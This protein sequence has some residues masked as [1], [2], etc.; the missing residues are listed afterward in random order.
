LIAQLQAQ[1]A[2]LQAQILELIQAQ[3][4]SSSWCYTFNE[5][6]IQG[7]SGAGV[8]ALQAAMQKSGYIIDSS[9]VAST[10]FGTSTKDAVIKFQQK[11]SSEILSPYGYTSGTGIVGLMTRTKLNNLY[12]CSTTDTDDDV[13]VT[14]V[15][16]CSS[17]YDCGNTGFTGDAFCSSG[18]VYQ[19]YTTYTCKNAGKSN[20]FCSVGTTY[21]ARDNCSSS[22]V[23]SNGACVAVS[24]TDDDNDDNDDDDNEIVCTSSSSC[25]SSGYTGDA[26]CQSGNVYKAYK[27]Y[28]CNNPGISSSYCSSS[29][30]DKLFDT[31]SSSETCSNGS[32]VAKEDD[33]TTTTTCT[34]NWSCGSWTTCSS[35]YQTRSCY[36]A[37]YCGVTTNKPSEQQSCTSSCTPNW[38]C[39]SWGTCS[40]SQQT[41]SCYDTNYCGVT[42]NKPSEQQSCTS[43]CTPDWSCGSW[44]TCVNSLQTRYCYDTNYCGSQANKPDDYQSCVSSTNGNLSVDLK[45]NGG[46]GPITVAKGSTVSFVWSSTDVNSCSASTS[47]SNSYWSGN[48]ATSGIVSV[49]VNATGTYYL[50]CTNADGDMVED[51]VVINVVSVDLKING[52]ESLTLPYKSTNSLTL[53][54]SSSGVNSCSVTST[55][56][57]SVWSGTKANSGSQVLGAIPSSSNFATSD[58]SV[59]YSITCANSAGNSASDSVTLFITHPTATLKIGVSY[60]KVGPTPTSDGPL[61]R[62]YGENFAL[63]WSSTNATSCVKKTTESTSVY[64]WTQDT[65]TSGNFF[66]GQALFGATYTLTCKDSVGNEASDTVELRVCDE[67][68]FG[69]TG[70]LEGVYGFYT[71]VC[72]SNDRQATIYTCNDGKV[73]RRYEFCSGGCSA[74]KCI[75]RYYLPG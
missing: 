74:G 75:E 44:G 48:K 69:A 70:F 2:T 43:S 71:N 24:T 23:C 40:N 47:P 54:W 3:Q 14:G 37:N 12:G 18:S 7:N 27:T 55:N 32:C 29:V 30:A 9:E 13:E 63:G 45:V 57:D 10:L 53:T 11:Y 39:G 4:T 59:T 66:Y 5:T 41:R 62:N 8:S 6:L 36:D 35:G 19:T 68:S 67:S 72:T 20:S 42:T 58:G 52:Q 61:Y 51:T 56:G 50:K 38:S 28:K 64:S 34:P 33:D 25:G 60:G 31:C 1:I 26:F 22:E 16:K 21:K 46:D 73:M 49:L 17:D 15:I 65:T